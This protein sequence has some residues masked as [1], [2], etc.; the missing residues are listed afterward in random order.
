MPKQGASKPAS[1]SP[2]PDVPD[3]ISDHSD[4][5]TESQKSAESKARALQIRKDAENAKKASDLAE[6]EKAKR[7]K[8][9][10][11]EKLIKQKRHGNGGGGSGSG[12]TAHS[13]H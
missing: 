4:S 9:K 10:S 8:A 1:R 7:Q 2:T 3:L 11:K 5:T 12:G 6:K 13:G